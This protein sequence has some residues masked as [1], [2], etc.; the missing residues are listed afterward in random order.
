MYCEKVANIMMIMSSFTWAGGY[1]WFCVGSY[2]PVLEKLPTSRLWKSEPETFRARDSP[3]VSSTGL[4][5]SWAGKHAQLVLF[6]RPVA[7]SN[8]PVNITE[9]ELSR[10][11]AQR[12]K[13]T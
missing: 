6:E 9:C 10:Y 3:S 2:D 11:L 5:G 12:C 7:L 1:A 13:E 8:R 4:S